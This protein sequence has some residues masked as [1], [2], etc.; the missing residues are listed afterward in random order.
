MSKPGPEAFWTPLLSRAHFSLPGKQ[1]GWLIWFLNF[2]QAYSVPW[3]AARK[4]L[5]ALSPA[6]CPTLSELTDLVASHSSQ[7]TICTIY[8]WIRCCSRWREKAEH[9]VPLHEVPIC[10]ATAPVPLTTQ[11][12]CPSPYD[13]SCLL[14]LPF[15]SSPFSG[16]LCS[17]LCGSES[18]T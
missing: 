14:L 1:W 11:P 12:P 2:L 16:V 18:I 3:L 7:E 5:A 10:V 8:E 4:I 9:C 6:V 15:A 17:L 13:T